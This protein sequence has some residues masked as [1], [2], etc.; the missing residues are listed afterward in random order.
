MNSIKE[1]MQ[2]RYATKKFDTSKELSDADLNYILE[3]GNLAATSYGLQPFG[4]VVVTDEEKKIQL[5]EAAYGQAQVGTSR[6]LLVLCGRTD[7]DTDFIAA[8]TK[9]IE[10]TRGMDAGAVDG[11]KDMM[12][13]DLTNRAP[14][15]V[16][17]WAVK[18]SYI[19]LGTMMVAAGEKQVDGSPMEGFDTAK[20]KEILGLDAHHLQPAALLALGYRSDEDETQHYT[21]VRRNLEDIV[22]RV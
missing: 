1:M 16:T 20:F 18:Q 7:V 14:E 6:A 17:A 13:S 15:D 10:E 11:Y 9:N 8:Y 2:W 21:K 3:A 4:I 5:Q 22:V 19:A 12:T